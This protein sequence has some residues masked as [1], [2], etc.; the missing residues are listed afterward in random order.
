MK[1]GMGMNTQSAMIN[2][3]RIWH[4]K[5][6][7]QH[8]TEYQIKQLIASNAL[9]RI[10]KGIYVFRDAAEPNED[11]VLAQQFY[12]KAV[13]SMFTAANFYGLTTVIPRAVQLTLP[14]SGTR[15]LA[16]PAYPTI[17]FFFTSEKTMELG[18]S[19]F[20]VENHS[21][22]IYDRERVVCDMFRYLSRTGIDTSIEV[23]KNY[24]KDKKNRDVDKLIHFS[25]QLRVYKY[26]SQYV[27]VYIG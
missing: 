1:G 5:D 18:L 7:L 12:P 27:E 11:M 22:R 19:S 25:R 8:M 16:R 4:K 21:V 6:L 10:Q 9:E 24:M 23:F 3:V 26:I 2:Q 20:K 15:H 13:M 14:S 17:E